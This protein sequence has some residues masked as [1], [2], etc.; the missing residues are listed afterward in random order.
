MCRGFSIRL[1]F[2]NSAC[3]RA[4][5]TDQKEGQAHLDVVVADRAHLAVQSPM[6]PQQAAIELDGRQELSRGGIDGAQ[7]QSRDALCALGQPQAETKA[8]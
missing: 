2:L 1:C 7:G 6:G 3:K 8:K 5:E 4:C